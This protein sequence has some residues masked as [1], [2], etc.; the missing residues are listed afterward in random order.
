MNSEES[1]FMAA[2]AGY[3]GLG[4][5]PSDVQRG[6]AGEFGTGQPSRVPVSMGVM[7]PYQAAYISLKML[8]RSLPVQNRSYGH[9]APVHQGTIRF[10]MKRR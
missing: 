10:P 5:V 8:C 7:W 6:T 3:D 9:T 4:R 2:A 1:E